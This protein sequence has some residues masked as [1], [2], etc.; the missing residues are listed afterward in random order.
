MRPLVR[1]S[2]GNGLTDGQGWLS[3]RIA[4]AVLSGIRAS[5][6]LTQERLAELTA[7]TVPTIQ[8]WESGRRPMTQM[9]YAELLKLRRVLLLAGAPEEQLACWDSAL[10]AD[11]IY[12]DMPGEVADQHPLGLTVPNRGLTE[13]LLWPMSGVAP[14]IL[15]DTPAKLLVPTGVRDDIASS[16]RD[17]VERSDHS[18]LVGSMIS[19]QACYL[20]NDHTPSR[21]W[22]ANVSS[23]ERQQSTDL[24]RW[25]ADWPAARSAAIAAAATGDLDPLLRF[26][27][28]GLSTDQEMD[29]NLNYW[30]YWVGE[31][32]TAWSSDAD[33][34]DTTAPWAGVRL[35]RSLLDGL[36]T[37]VPYRELCAH[38]LWGLLKRKRE[39]TQDLVVRTRIA[40]TIESTISTP[41][42]VSGE[43]RRRLEQVAYLVSE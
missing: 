40:R 3:G 32:A 30:A 11:S 10:V 28:E 21:D 37:D 7:R 42:K 12:D 1:H 33:M 24:S 4:G 43:A 39:L 25:S 14:R 6:G 13:L 9:R 31:S 34:L 41:G 5:L 19:R 20:L 29:A 27:E 15:R 16:L 22:L 26:V 18:S 8:S 35:L 38:S 36:D 17:V 23:V 2:T